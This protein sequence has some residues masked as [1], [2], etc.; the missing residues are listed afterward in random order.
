MDCTKKKRVQPFP[1][2]L[3]LRRSFVT[4][5]HLCSLNTQP[6]VAFG[7]FEADLATGELWKAG[8]R[9]RLQS[10]PFRV[11]CVLVCE[12]G[13]V[14][15]TLLLSRVY[16]Q[17]A[18]AG[19]LDAIKILQGISPVA[20]GNVQLIGNFDFTDGSSVVDIEA[21]AAHYQNEDFWRRSMTESNEDGPQ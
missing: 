15:T 13:E 17:K 18:A 3:W 2:T 20:W 21:L 9:I 5:R 1:F 16:E 11:L 4:R 12:A 8:H 19:D 10:Q 6:G 14:V 7:L